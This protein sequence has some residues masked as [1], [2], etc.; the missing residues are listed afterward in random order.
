M[1]L[2]NY[3]GICNL[4]FTQ[5]NPGGVTNDATILMG[6]YNSTSDGAGAYA[7]YPGSTASGKAAGDLWINNDSVSTTDLPIGSYDQFVFLHE[8]GHAMG[9]AHPGDYNAAP[10]VS[11]TYAHNAQFVED[12]QIGR[13]HV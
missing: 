8:L 13:A 4:T 7:N 9:L 6:A 11:I 12:S 10:G 2:A 5:V 3:A 1:A